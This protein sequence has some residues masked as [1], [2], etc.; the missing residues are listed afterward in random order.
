MRCQGHSEK[1]L[2]TEAISMKNFL[3]RQVPR[4]SSIRVFMMT[5]NTKIEKKNDDGKCLGWPGS[6]CG[7][8]CYCLTSNSTSQDI[9]EINLLSPI[10]QSQI[11]FFDHN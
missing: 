8:R 6:S 4:L 1:K 2:K 3:L 9:N 11:R 10:V 7:P 5:I